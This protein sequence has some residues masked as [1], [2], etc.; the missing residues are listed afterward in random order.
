MKDYRLSEIAANCAKMDE[1][2]VEKEGLYL[3]CEIGE[4]QNNEICMLCRRI[5]R[6]FAPRV[7]DI[8]PRD[9]I[10]LPYINEIDKS[11]TGCYTLDSKFYE[12][13][14]R[15]KDGSIK[16]MQAESKDEANKFLAMLKETNYGN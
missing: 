4:E 16:V 14:F 11:K 3:A 10:E 2:A 8:E 15:D 12:V 1:L 5:M 9:M 7:F 6:I 13:I